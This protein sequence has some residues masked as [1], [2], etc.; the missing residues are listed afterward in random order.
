[1]KKILLCFLLAIPSL[2]SAQTAER[3]ERLLEQKQVNYRDAAL[4]V[5]EAAG[6]LDNVNQTNA[7]DA[8][9]LAMD[10]GW[11]PKDTQANDSARLNNISLLLMRSFNMKGGIMY[12]LTKNRRYAYRQLTYLNVIQNRSDPS[13]F[14]SGE[15]LLYYVNRILDMEN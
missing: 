4:L 7:D 14:V 11:L 6:Q 2:L 5:L 15:R 12:A 9:S 1:M 10:R 3:I 8:F 13:D